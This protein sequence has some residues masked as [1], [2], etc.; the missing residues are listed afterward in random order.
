MRYVP[1]TKLHPIIGN[2]VV[3]R[4]LR[5]ECV[6]TLYTGPD[7]WGRAEARCAELNHQ[8]A[9]NGKAADVG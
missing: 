5:K 1:K 8:E 4:D 3:V 6:V 9:V 2:H 7:A